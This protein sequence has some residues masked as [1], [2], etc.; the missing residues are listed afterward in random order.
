M[1]SQVALAHP[2]PDVDCYKLSIVSKK[3]ILRGASTGLGKTLPQNPAWSP[4]KAAQSPEVTALSSTLS[5]QSE[6]AAGAHQTGQR[7]PKNNLIL[8]QFFSPGQQS[9]SD[10]GQSEAEMFY[11]GNR[12]WGGQPPISYASKSALCGT[13]FEQ[14]KG[15]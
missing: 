13:R 2:P 10:N 4:S 14:A 5:D 1:T 7:F 15:R 8:K 9:V 12:P 6:M 11:K 3:S